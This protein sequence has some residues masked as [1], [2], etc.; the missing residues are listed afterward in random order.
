LPKL[1]NGVWTWPLTKGPL[2]DPAI[3]ALKQTK[4]MGEAKYNGLLTQLQ[5]KAYHGFSGKASYTKSRCFSN[6]DS[7]NNFQP[8]TNT[9]ADIFFF[10]KAM[11]GPCDF[12]LHGNFVGNAIYNPPAPGTGPLKWIAGGWQLGGI[13]SASSGAPFSLFTGGD[14]LN[15]IA[16]AGFPECRGWLQSLRFQESRA[17]ILSEPSLLRFGAG[18]AEWTHSRKSRA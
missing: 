16:A 1:I 17:A 9:L 15:M 11:W 8:Y 12:D 7:A 14:P 5:L 13:V 4:W 6:G 3:T 10:T 2:A 18:H